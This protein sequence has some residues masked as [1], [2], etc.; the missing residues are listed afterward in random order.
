MLSSDL[1]GLGVPPELA[2]TLSSGGNGPLTITAAGTAFAS[3]TLIDESQRVLSCSNGL[4]PQGLSLPTVGT[5]AGC[6]LADAFVINNAGTTSLQ[7][8]A[9]TGVLISVD[10]ANTVTATI[11]KHNTTIFYP[12][13]TTQWIGVCGA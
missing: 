4:G 12:V 6:L 1:M 3:G 2:D 8:F 13:T 7:I 10:A 11:Q 9:S 5:D